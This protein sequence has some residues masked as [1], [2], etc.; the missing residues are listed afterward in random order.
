MHDGRD[1]RGRLRRK[2]ERQWVVPLVVVLGFIALVG[3]FDRLVVRELEARKREVQARAQT[4]AAA[5]GDQIGNT[6]SNR[7]GAMR[8]AKL[9]F[10]PV[11]DSLSERA[12]LAAADS[13]TKDLIGLSAISVIYADSTLVRGSGAAL[14][15]RGMSLFA[16]SALVNAHRRALALR[17]PASTG[18][19]ET[20]IGRRVIVFDPVW[21]SQDSLQAA[22][23]IAGELDPGAILRAAQA[24]LQADSLAGGFYALFGPGGTMIT[25]VGL[26]PV[27]GVVDHPIRVADTEWTLRMAYEPVNPAMYRAF[28]IALWLT[29]ISIGLAF[30]FFIFTL[31]RRLLEQRT[32]IA[33]QQEEI[34]RRQLAEAEARGL[35]ERLAQQAAELSRA[36]AL[37]RGREGDARELASQLEAAQRAAQRLSSSLDPED[38]VELFLGTVAERVNADVASLYTFDE[39]GEVLIGRQ[40]IIFRDAGDVTDRLRNENIGQVRAP[41]ALLPPGLAAAVATGEPYAAD[42]G[43]GDTPIGV[44]VG[45]DTSTTVLAVPLLVGGH[46][47]GVASWDAY[48]DPRP[49]DAATVTF[50]QALGTTTAAALHTAE[51]FKSL[52]R[53]REDAQREALRFRTLIDQM[54][55]GVVLVDAAAAVERTNRAAEELL[56]AGLADIPLEQW[57]SQFNLCGAEGRPLAPAD[58][59]LR[60]ALRGEHVRRVEFISRAQPGDERHLSGSA[61]P[62]LA[63]NGEAAGAALVFRDVTDERHYAEM[64]RHTNRQLREQTEILELVNTQLR[65]ATKA[66][67]QFLAVMSHELRTPMN[68]IMGYAELLQMGLKGEL[69]SGQREMLERIGNASRHLLG[70]I[71]QVLDLAKIQAGQLELVL[72]PVDVREV[73]DECL[74]HVAPLAARKNLALVLEPEQLRLPQSI[75]VRGDKTRITQILLNLLSNAVKFT[76]AGRVLVRYESCDS[77]VEIRVRDT[78]PGIAAEQLQRIFEEFYQVEGHL[79]RKA[80]GT[81][82]GLPIARRLARM[83]NGDLRVESRVSEGSEFIVELP[84]AGAEGDV[85]AHPTSISALTP[86]DRATE[87]QT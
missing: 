81:G 20:T 45:S 46:V 2:P 32:S 23:V 41:V 85:I 33:K 26:P 13:A 4:R 16:D 83:M 82:L 73:I 8:T 11:H 1:E 77:K 9:Q 63:P 84:S 56:G 18:V 47:V 12:F 31:R 7:I 65:E 10:T 57:P 69:N 5:L 3:F 49:F 53:A 58:L 71:N 14:G 6:V 22:G 87:L 24:D 55:D 19:L 40:R 39:E 30:A 48:D 72:V 44:S 86:A 62:L 68:A 64:L 37:A 25:S 70:L 79:T 59:P 61:A 67:D 21:S 34:A 28:R 35:A 54:A 38:I 66:K 36:E 50:A 75:R 29:G 27:W 15:G 74:S 60:R 43:A 76:D 52:E 80:G 17:K 51:L 78:G 42:M